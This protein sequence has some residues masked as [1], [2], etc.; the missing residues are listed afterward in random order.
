MK[1]VL[2]LLY[3]S[4]LL[5][6]ISAPFADTG[7]RDVQAMVQDM[8]EDQIEVR[9]ALEVLEEKAR[10]E[11]DAARAEARRGREKIAA[12]RSSLEQAIAAIE[13]ALADEEAAVAALE[14][15]GELLAEQERQLT[16]Q[17]AATDAVISELVGVIR[18]FAKDITSHIAGSLQ[19]GL[20]QYR[21]DLLDGIAQQGR[22]PGIEEIK[23]MI[24]LLWRQISGAGSVRLQRAAIVDRDGNPVE[25]DVLVLGDFTAAYRLDGEIGYLAHT[26]ATEKLFALRALPP[27]T[28]QKQL[29]DYIEG[30][31]EAVPL[32]ISRG[33]ALAQLSHAVSPW[34]RIGKGGPL[35]WPILGILAAAVLLILER[36]VFL[37]RTRLPSEAFMIRINELAAAR[38]WQQCSM[39]CRQRIGKPLARVLA[40]GLESV[41]RGREV[42]ENALQEAI[43]REVP[44]MERFL[45]TLG[46]LAAIAPLLGLLGT[47]T[48]M[49]STFD[50]IT[51]YG[52]GDPRMMSGGI[53]EALITTMLGLSVAIPIMLVHNLLNRSV[54]NRIA[55]MEE[56]AVALVNIVQKNGD[57][58]R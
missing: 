18:I 56:K 57:G 54:D 32:D 15:E 17:L 14:E 45:S 36:I 20:G 53:S 38:D 29:R 9:K 37:F 10:L 12:D 5:L 44:P 46:M 8:R 58:N 34:Q 25:A 3:L 55:I 35:V 1:I 24:A 51:L 31:G 52:T 7:T 16:E 28:L 33:A 41:H 13:T 11:H 39:E 23:E 19:H 47:V 40:A 48:G 43:L 42:M 50:V 22:F 6:P 30:N 2:L 26:P 27:R 4:F 49:I 21:G